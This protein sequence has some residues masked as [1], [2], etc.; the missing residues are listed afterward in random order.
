MRLNLFVQGNPIARTY[1][2]RVKKDRSAE[3]LT[4]PTLQDVEL[5]T[6]EVL[7]EYG[8]EIGVTAAAQS[9][10]G[11]Y[12]QENHGRTVNGPTNVLATVREAPPP[13]P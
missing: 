4:P 12:L 3:I 13:T 5:A 9:K 2:E 7:D 10:G 1:T 6:F 11:K 8:Q